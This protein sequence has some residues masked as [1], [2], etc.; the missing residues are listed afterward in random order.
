MSHEEPLTRAEMQS[1][2]SEEVALIDANMLRQRPVIDAPHGR[3]IQMRDHAAGK[4]GKRST[5]INWASNDYLGASN[6]IKQ[7]NAAR[8]SLRTWGTGSGA[9][10]LLS[11]GLAL[12][13]RFEQRLAHFLGAEDALL[14]TTGYQANI[15]A[16]VALLGDPED[17]VILD[18]LVQARC[19]V[20][21]IMTWRIWKNNCA[22]PTV[23]GVALSVLRVFIRWTVM[24]HR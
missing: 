3:T 4:G 10:R 19:C 17:V 16:L 6:L 15:A 2:L 11:G 13:R 9:A 24:R 23:H 12:H 14:C 20:L 22:G 7:K 5:L 8:S 21:S 1:G 18:R